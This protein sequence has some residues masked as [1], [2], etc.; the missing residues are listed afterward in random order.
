M[1]V[2]V[3]K[4]VAAEYVSVDGVMQDPGG[5]GEIE[6]GGWTNPYWN[7]EL[8]K[9]QADL[10]FASDALLL[11]RVTYEGFAAAWPDMEQ[12]EGPFAVKMNT[13]PKYVA[14]RT[15]TDMEWNAVLIE[16]D[17][18]EEV[19][20][21]KRDSGQNLLIYGSGSLVR[22]LLQHG[23]IDQ[24]RLMI[25]PVVLA[26]GKPL[27]TETGG[28]KELPLAGVTTT[29]AGVVVVDY[30]KAPSGAQK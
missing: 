2:P 20:K 26:A 8:A 27:F 5:V 14:S 21:L 6:V 13:M 24:L 16:G 18:A 1:E 22:L 11:G 7:D 10:L 30:T 9:L 3:G 12:E 23:L 29:S 28:K 25:H 19:A 15:L 17:V 4:I